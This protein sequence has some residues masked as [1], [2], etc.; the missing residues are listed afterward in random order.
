M[1]II[2]W[3]I[4]LFGVAVICR[5]LRARYQ[6]I[7]WIVYLIV[8]GVAIMTWITEG[9]WMALL[10]FFIGAIIAK[11]LFGMGGGTTVHKF[12]HDYELE[13]KEC[14]YDDLEIIDENEIGV[15]TRCKR[16]GAVCFH[17]LLH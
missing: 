4:V 1:G 11:V 2:V 7:D 5:V 12:G 6:A 13:C 17:R 16:C 10:S 9:F 14:G 8:F 15:N 3:L